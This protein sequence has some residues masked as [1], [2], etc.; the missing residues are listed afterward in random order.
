MHRAASPRCSRRRPSARA[1]G[2]RCVLGFLLLLAV[3][4]MVLLAL[5]PPR[6]GERRQRLDARTPRPQLSHP[7]PVVGRPHPAADAFPDPVA[8]FP[9]VEAQAAP[10]AEHVPVEKSIEDLHV[11]SLFQWLRDNVLLLVQL[12]IVLVLIYAVM[13]FQVHGGTGTGKHYILMIDSSASMGVADADGGASR[14]EAAKKAALAGDRRPRRRRRRHGHRV[15]LRRH[16]PPAVHHRPRQ[17][18]PR[19]RGHRADASGPRASRRR[20]T[21]PTASP[22]RCAPPTTWPSRPD[23]ADPAKARTYVPAEGVAA[24][25]HLFSDGRFPDVA[26]FAAGNLDLNYHRVGKPRRSDN[27]GIVAFNAV[28]DD[29]GSSKL[30]VFV[31]VLNFRSQEVQTRVQLDEMDW[32]DGELRVDGLATSS[33]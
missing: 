4:G 25:V 33:R 18:P 31:R 24:E 20:S 1:S 17:A 8:L 28:R 5:Q 22:T 12:L 13:A 30:Q 2:S 3:P 9:Q 29:K 23:N 14:L 11:N 7:L 19:R 10:G 6:Q 15:Q 16:D 32:K 27:V 21:W 26:G